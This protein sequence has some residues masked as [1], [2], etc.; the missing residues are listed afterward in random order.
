MSRAHVGFELLSL[1]ARGGLET[2]GE[3]LAGRIDFA[4]IV[5]TRPL[6]TTAVSS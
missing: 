3:M 5:S 4:A 2:G 1:A 6:T